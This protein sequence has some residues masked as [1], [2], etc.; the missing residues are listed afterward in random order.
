M[1]W[2][3]DEQTRAQAEDLLRDADALLGSTPT[4]RGTALGERLTR[5]TETLGRW[6]PPDAP[7]AD[8]AAALAVRARE[9]LLRV[10]AAEVVRRRE[11]AERMQQALRTL[12]SIDS[13]Q[14]LVDR[15]PD[16]VAKLGFNRVLLSWV[17][18]GRWVPVSFHTESGPEEARAV[19]EAGAPPYH[20]LRRLLEGEMV[21]RRRP[22]LVRD[23][24][25]HPRVHQDI[26]AVMHSHS[27]V[28]APVLRRS[29][30]VGFVSADQNADVDVVDEIDRDLIQLFADGLGL[31]LDRV[32]VLE[33]LA[34][35]RRRIGEQAASM[36]Q[37]IS[38][39]EPSLATPS[40]RAPDPSWQQVLTRRE[41][42]VLGLVAAGLSNAQIAQR[43]YVTEGTA[44]TH[45]KN[46]LRKLGA[47]NR[48]R[49]GALYREHRGTTGG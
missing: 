4:D 32:A 2:V 19:M 15:V 48:A 37:L 13:T 26:Q 17:D 31:A 10:Q 6:T 41:E 8:R 23:A 46:V 36:S 3:L 24:L 34:D 38:G 27:Y 22:I 7:R 43:L 21:S 33:E 1:T 9:L 11:S 35:L 25:D 49:A 12:Q 39:P 28:A 40:G 20:D 14:E 16:E 5:T 30:V 18:H 42:E 45:V 47:E 44:K 29:Q